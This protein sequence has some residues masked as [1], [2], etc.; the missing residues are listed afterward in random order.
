MNAADWLLEVTC[1]DCVWVL[2]AG[3]R[4]EAE[5]KVTAESQ[6]GAGNFE[7]KVAVAVALAAS[8]A[9]GF[10]TSVRS[11]RESQY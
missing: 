9:A 4:G 3:H 8:K 6:V 10:A 1:S 11:V 7:M 5:L 2:D